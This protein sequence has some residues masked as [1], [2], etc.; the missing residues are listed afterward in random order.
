MLET[1]ANKSGHVLLDC[2]GR[3]TQRFEEARHR[4]D[5]GCRSGGRA[6]YL[7]EWDKVRRIP[8]VSTQR[9]PR[10]PQQCHDLRNRDYRRI[11]RKERRHGGQRLYCGEDLLLEREILGARLND[12][13]G[14]GNRCLQEYVPANTIGSGFLQAELTQ[15]AANARIECCEHLRGRIL[16][17][18]RVS[19]TREY[20]CD[21][22]T[23]EAA[24]DNRDA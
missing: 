6:D 15:I 20:L 7:N 13:L 11:A 8:P 19:G 17:P 2:D 21:A 1:V 9:T 24:A 5:R 23:H 4:R 16:N 12:H 18:N 3:F 10:M 22:V 14:V